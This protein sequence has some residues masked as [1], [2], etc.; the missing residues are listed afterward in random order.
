MS[1]SFL[2]ALQSDANGK[3][4]LSGFQLLLVSGIC[5]FYFLAH[6]PILL[7]IACCI[8]LRIFRLYY[9]RKIF[10]T[11]FS[12]FFQN[13]RSL[14][15]SYS[16]QKRYS[17]PSYPL[18]LH[19]C[20]YLFVCQYYQSISLFGVSSCLPENSTDLHFEKVST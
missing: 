12:S 1:P 7:K 15:P 17:K 19:D 9:R 8:L 10:R 6:S 18:E 4:Y 16:P 11:F 14:I 20:N 5:E 2:H 3:A 13:Q